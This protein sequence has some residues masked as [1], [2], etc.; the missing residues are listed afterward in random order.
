VGAAVVTHVAATESWATLEEGAPIA[1]V[2]LGAPAVLED[3]GSV[4]LRRAVNLFHRNDLPPGIDQDGALAAVGA[5]IKA[6]GRGFLELL[7]N[8]TPSYQVA[9]DGGGR[10][11]I[12]D[13]SGARM[14]NVGAVDVGAPNA[15]E[16]VV[17]RLV[18][19]FRYQTI[20]GIDE[21]F[22]RL[23]D[24]LR[25]ELRAPPPAWSPGQPIQGGTVIEPS[26]DAYVAKPGTYLFVHVMNGSPRPIN[27]VALDLDD[28]WAIVALE[29]PD[30]SMGSN[31]TVDAR[32]DDWFA[33][34]AVLRGGRASALDIIKIF[35]TVD[36]TD[37]WWLL[38]PPLDQRITRS[39]TFTNPRNALFRLREALEAD[40][41]T[42][43]GLPA[44]GLGSDWAVRQIRVVTRP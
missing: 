30:P 41:N 7:T 19:I 39:P 43:A 13:P 3:V 34:R 32:K 33:F 36:D 10:Y 22:S 38:Q 40:Q 28:D 18:H 37:F 8:G 29:P 21:P 24:A 17:E 6:R 9:V 26:G 12:W 5:A 42:R 31:I 44:F 1:A 11:E 16:R 23:E 15:A 25:V 27:I 4:A 2:E 14:P 35:A 20:L